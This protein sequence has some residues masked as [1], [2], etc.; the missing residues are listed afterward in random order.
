MQFVIVV[1][2]N[3]AKFYLLDLIKK[4]VDLC[5]S[6]GIF[7]DLLVHPQFILSHN[8]SNNTQGWV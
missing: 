8:E 4:K 6:N 1:T 3:Q 2:V 7:V 5:S